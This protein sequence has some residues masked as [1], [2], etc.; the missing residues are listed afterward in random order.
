MFDHL[1]A[2]CIWKSGL[3]YPSLSVTEATDLLQKLSLDSK[4]K[5]LEI[6]DATKKVSYLLQACN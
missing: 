3:S 1:N 2:L 6:T 5:T 4:T